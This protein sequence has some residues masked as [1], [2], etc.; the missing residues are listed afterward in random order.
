MQELADERRR[1]GELQTAY[2]L[3]ERSKFARVRELWRDLLAIAGA[4]GKES[5]VPS[6]GGESFASDGPAAVRQ[7]LDLQAQNAALID[8]IAAD[9]ARSGPDEKYARW[10]DTYGPRERDFQRM[11]DTIPALTVRP[12]VSII[13][14]T[15]NTSERYLRAAIE[16]VLAQIYPYW[17][18]CIA[19]DA[20]PDS[21]VR[22]VL[23]EYAARDSRIKLV[24]RP[25]NGHISRASNSAL[26]LASGDFVAF[27]DH[28]DVLSADALFEVANLVERHPDA[29]MIYSDEDKIDDSGRL[30]DP[31][32]KPDW[33]PDSFLS[34]MYTCHF[35]AYRRE[36]VERLGRLRPEFDGSQDYDLVLRLTEQTDRIHHIPKVLYHWRVHAASTASS[37]DVKPYA[38]TAAERALTEALER[39]GE[40]GTAKARTDCSGTYVVR[41]DIRDAR[42]VSVIVPTRDHG[43]DVDRCLKSIFDAPQYDN[44]EIII[45]D[46]GSTEPASLD[47]FERWTKADSR[48]RVLRYDVPF[49]FSRI[50]NYAASESDGR[51]LLF[52]NNDT[53][54]VSPDWMA[55]M[56]E[57][58]QRPS[59]G[60]VGALLLYP[61]RTIQHAGA[62]IGVGGVAGHSHKYF[63]ADAPG[64][65]NIVKAVNNYSAVTAACMMVRRDAFEQVGGFD[66]RLAVAFNDID[67]CLK[68]R[69]AGYRNVYLPHAILIHFESKS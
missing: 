18:L 42:K 21:G 65:F 25:V 67:F 41:Y 13:M 30:T 7:I 43:D 15:Y 47:V 40:P 56:V 53:E 44:F 68:L 34:R 63:P 48:V 52:L 27:L 64:Y 3:I 22:R 6:A 9:R 62:V 59:I 33:S 19:D 37:G 69:A 35:S 54:V 14:A 23:A 45:V 55:A 26:D 24:Q 66:E 17:E 39:R 20:S 12:T 32:F 36:L 10:R 51:Y 2:R 11:R 8:T 4:I 57:Q 58:A 50:N 29:D 16:S 61:D 1:L 46:N 38:A 28:D 5:F 60:A 49:N 31:H